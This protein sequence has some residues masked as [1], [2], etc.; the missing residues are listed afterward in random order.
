M[1]RLWHEYS[2]GWMY[3]G[4]WLLTWATHAMLTYWQQEGYPPHLAPWWL[5]FLT[6]TFEN[7]ASEYHQVGAFIVLAR[8]FRFK[9][10]PQSRDGDDAMQDQLTELGAQLAAT[11]GML[12]DLLR[13]FPPDSPTTPGVLPAF[14]R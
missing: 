9:D 2:L 11:Q 7:L 1:K 6:T 4:G 13:R 8:W 14:D 12:A 5:D 10:S 3:L